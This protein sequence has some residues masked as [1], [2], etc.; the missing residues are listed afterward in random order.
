[1]ISAV[2]TYGEVY[3]EQKTGIAIHVAVVKAS[4]LLYTQFI[5]LRMA[6]FIIFQF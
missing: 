3:A 6:C 1:M 2:F 4:P 5:Y